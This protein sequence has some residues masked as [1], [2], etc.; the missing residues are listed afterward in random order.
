MGHIHGTCTTVN[1]P[2]PLMLE[3][4]NKYM[5]GVDKSDQMISYHKVSRRTVNYWKS[6]FYHFIDI[7]TDNSHIIYN[8]LAIQKGMTTLTEN[9]FRDK[10]VLQI[11]VK[12]GME[13]QSSTSGGRAPVRACKVQ[14]GS[15]LYSRDNRQRCVSGLWQ[16]QE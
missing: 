9:Q 4:Y 12:Y 7:A 1:V 14:H 16:L 13:S 15:Q 10:L 6:I 8:Y 5:G 2:C 3:H 11:I